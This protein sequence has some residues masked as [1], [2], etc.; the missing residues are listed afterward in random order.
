MNK[1]ANVNSQEAKK[2][3]E[4]CFDNS[5]RM[6]NSIFKTMID[7]LLRLCPD[8]TYEKCYYTAIRQMVSNNK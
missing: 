7:I 6:E 1:E 8:M 2:V 4:A 5:L 3:I